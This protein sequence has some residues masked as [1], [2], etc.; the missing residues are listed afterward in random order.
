MSGA[1]VALDRK[2]LGSEHRGLATHMTNLAML[3]NDGGRAAERG[4]G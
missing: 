4:C 1:P 2:V 3:L